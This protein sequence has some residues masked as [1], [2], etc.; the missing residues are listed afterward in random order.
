MNKLLEKW[1]MMFDLLDL[2]WSKIE[3]DLFQFKIT[4]PQGDVLVAVR[5]VETMRPRALTGYEFMG[6]YDYDADLDDEHFP[7]TWDAARKE[8][9]LR[10]GR[11]PCE[12]TMGAL[13]DPPPGA[14]MLWA[15]AHD[16]LG[17]NAVGGF[18]SLWNHV[19][20]KFEDAP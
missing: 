3:D 17:G 13:L 15:D 14:R 16:R 10:L 18:Q 19:H 4:I 11:Y 5:D 2:D 1:E 7:G 20:D 6:V 8:W 9:V 12:H